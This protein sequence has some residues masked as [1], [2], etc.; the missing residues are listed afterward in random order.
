MWGV[1][2]GRL[3]ERVVPDREM[4]S[5]REALEERRVSG[6]IQSWEIDV[7]KDSLTVWF[8]GESEWAPLSEAMSFLRGAAMAT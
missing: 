4:V 1:S 8:D 3:S 6:V 5:I 2:F 7:D